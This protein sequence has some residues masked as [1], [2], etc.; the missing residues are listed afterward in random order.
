[1]DLENAEKIAKHAWD[2]FTFAGLLA[3]LHGGVSCCAQLVL[4]FN[5]DEFQPS[6]CFEILGQ[7]FV[8][9]TYYFGSQVSLRMRREGRHSRFIQRSIPL[10]IWYSTV[11]VVV[12]YA[13]MREQWL[14]LLWE[15]LLFV[16]VWQTLEAE[17]KL[18]DAER[19]IG[20]AKTR[21]ERELQE[22]MDRLTC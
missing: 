17:V 9:V 1:M 15:L 2:I 6:I 13:L 21:Y 10:V 11:G 18:R 4:L 12:Y 3:V 14:L 7:V 5:D 8:A 20:W 19:K 16:T 22:L